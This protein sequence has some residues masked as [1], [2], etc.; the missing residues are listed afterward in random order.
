MILCENLGALEANRKRVFLLAA[1]PDFD[2]PDWLH[3]LVLRMC[4]PK[5]DPK[6]I[7][8][9][10]LCRYATKTARRGC[11][12]HG[13]L[14]CLR[15]IGAMLSFHWLFFENCWAPVLM[16]T[17]CVFLAT[18][19]WLIRAKMATMHAKDLKLPTLQHMGY[20]K[21]IEFNVTCHQNLVM[22]H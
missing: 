13:G 10:C 11:K 20:G 1:K 6:F 22:R 8:L 19:G 16:W 2:F 18:K 9:V 17:L 5:F 7:W 12:D 3:L 14:R 15:F 4:S 21:D